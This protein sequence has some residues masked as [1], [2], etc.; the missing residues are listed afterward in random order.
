VLDG[1]V[2]PLHMR[3]SD[4]FGV[5]ARRRQL[6]TAVA[7]VVVEEGSERDSSAHLADMDI[8][9]FDQEHALRTAISRAFEKVPGHLIE[10][11][12]EPLM[13]ELG[14]TV[15]ALL[16][17]QGVVPQS[18]PGDSLSAPPSFLGFIEAL[19]SGDFNQAS[20]LLGGGP[21]PRTDL[22]SEIVDTAPLPTTERYQPPADLVGGKGTCPAFAVVMVDEMDWPY[23]T[24]YFC[25]D[26]VIWH[27]IHNDT[28]MPRDEVLMELGDFMDS[29]AGMHT[30]SQ[31][32]WFSWAAAEMDKRGIPAERR[33]EG[34]YY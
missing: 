32:E 6:A 31:T 14:P 12:M 7:A 29:N 18:N 16:N 34:Q 19:T 28:S 3:R 26:A 15:A 22:F 1:S 17:E 27:R 20:A 4:P 30:N 2:T 9:S 10:A 21:V 11:A 25:D 23:N 5:S 33:I 8:L 13:Q 24:L